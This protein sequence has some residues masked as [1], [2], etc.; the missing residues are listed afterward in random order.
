MR[1]H[2]AEAAGERERDPGVQT[3]V[4]EDTHEIAVQGDGAQGRDGQGGE[5]G[6]PEGRDA[7]APNACASHRAAET[8]CSAARG[9]APPGRPASR[10]SS[11]PRKCARCRK[12]GAPKSGRPL[13]PGAP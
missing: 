2:V 12:W 4:V 8:D 13:A 5:P 11:P 6:G 1:M 7:G 10:S 3:V 9:T